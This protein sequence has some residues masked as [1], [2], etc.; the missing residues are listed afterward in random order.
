MF[1]NTSR[2][3]FH[4]A[5]MAW[6]RAMS[7]PDH[8]R[9]SAQRVTYITSGR[10]MPART[11]HDN[12]RA[13]EHGGPK[14]VLGGGVNQVPGERMRLPLRAWPHEKGYALGGKAGCVREGVC[15]R[16]D[17]RVVGVAGVDAVG[18]IEELGHAK[19]VHVAAV[20]AIL[21]HHLRPHAPDLINLVT[22]GALNPDLSS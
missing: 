22:I 16:P 7:P 17:S 5:D 9:K 12:E 20:R 21:P 13:A 19:R 1:Q 11:L 10:E 18:G 8:E 15:P 6:P 14:R 3:C 2:S 4:S